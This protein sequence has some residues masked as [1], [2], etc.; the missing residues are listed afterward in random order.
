MYSASAATLKWSQDTHGNSLVR[1]DMGT[2]NVDIARMQTL[3]SD[4]SSFL[5][6]RG[7]HKLLVHTKKRG[8]DQIWI[9]T[10]GSLKDKWDFT[11]SWVDIGLIQFCFTSLVQVKHLLVVQ[12]FNF[13]WTF[14][15]G[16]Y[17]SMINQYIH[18]NRK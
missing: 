5:V 10:L 6:G 2:E 16:S 18:V 17:T 13:L 4:E 12:W 8:S 11:G 9:N 14:N 3:M 15:I 7:T 1:S